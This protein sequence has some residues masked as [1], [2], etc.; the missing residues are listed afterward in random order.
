MGVVGP[1]Q[2]YRF[3]K[4]L[5]ENARDTILRQNIY[6]PH[7]PIWHFMINGC[8]IVSKWLFFHYQSRSVT[9]TSVISVAVKCFVSSISQ[10]FIV[11][12]IYRNTK[13]E[14][15]LSKSR[16]HKSILIY[17]PSMKLGFGLEG[18]VRIISIVRLRSITKLL[19]VLLSGLSM[20]DGLNRI[21]K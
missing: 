3:N 7:L 2:L 17:N 13:K 5:Y 20:L 19:T 18:A 9:Q 16:L 8:K 10:T 6:Q 14:C 21:K 11:C 12:N 4:T 15:I 1:L